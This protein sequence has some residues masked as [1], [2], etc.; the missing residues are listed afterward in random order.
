VAP[1]G[2]LLAR[3]GQ[4]DVRAFVL[5]IDP[6]TAKDKKVHKANDLFEDRRPAMYAR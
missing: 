4:D 3:L 5:D 2:A 6:W 1:N